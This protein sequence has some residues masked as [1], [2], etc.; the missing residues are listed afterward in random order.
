MGRRPA[1]RHPER[2]DHAGGDRQD[3]RPTCAPR[4]GRRPTAGRSAG[5][6]SSR[7]RRP[8][9]WPRSPRAGRARPPH[10]R[11][12]PAQPGR[13]A[14][15][16]GRAGRRRRRLQVRHDR[17]RD[18]RGRSS[19]AAGRAGRRRSGRAA[20]T[21]TSG[22]SSGP[23]TRG[24]RRSGG[25][26]P[27]PRCGA[28]RSRRSTRSTSAAA[29]RSA[30]SASRR[31]RPSGSRARSRRCSTRSRPTG[32]RP[33]WP[34]S[35]GG[36]WSRAPAGW[37]RASSTSATAADRQVI[38][39]AGMTELIRP[40]LYGARHPDRGADLAGRR[41]RRR[42]RD[43]DAADRASKGPICES[44][45]SLGV[46][47]LPPLRRGDL[48]AIADAGAYA[49][50]QASTYNGRPRPPQVLLDARRHAVARP[51][52]GFGRRARRLSFGRGC[53]RP[54]PRSPRPGPAAGRRRR[55]ARCSSR[56]GSRSAPRLDELVLTRPD[57]IGAIH[58]EYLA[59]GADLIETATFGANRI[60]LAAVRPR[61]PGRPAGAARRPDRPRGPR[62]GRPRRPRRRLRRA[63][64]ARR[65]TT[66]VHLDA[67][68]VRAAFREAIDG[69]LEGGVDLF[70]L[71][72]FSSLDHLRDRHR[73]GAPAAADRADRRAR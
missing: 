8:R 28:A 62:R 24:A 48:V 65:P 27:S 52:P 63:A 12:L 17:D 34:S 42:G 29:S 36:P 11:A 47:D 59:A 21:C 40:A 58:R 51:S 13:R 16:A 9:R 64:R 35:P 37:W 4:S 73:G 19:S 39:D 72:T 1:G 15:D 41:R 54:V 26:W 46:H 69:L 55:W 68:K 45:D 18:L 56:A 3:R 61:R 10:R 7:P 53:E 5:S 22:R 57:L 32:D 38:L 14:R 49:A 33:A 2:A 25:R 44:T 6:P 43:R 66:C 30:R 50:S 23:S 70:M 71:E 31:P 60:R 20:S 67:A